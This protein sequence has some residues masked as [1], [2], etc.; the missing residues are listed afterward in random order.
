MKIQFTDS[1]AGAR[2]AYR[3][4]EKADLQEDVAREFIGSGLAVALEAP[5]PVPAVLR[6]RRAAKERAV[7]PAYEKAVT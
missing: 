6:R 7:D 4:G 5:P 3:K 1:V 2:F